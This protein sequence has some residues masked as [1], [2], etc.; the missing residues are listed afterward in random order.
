MFQ[1]P[2]NYIYELNFI[3]IFSPINNNGPISILNAIP[4][5]FKNIVTKFLTSCL[6]PEIIHE[7]FGFKQNSSTELNL[8]TYVDIL[9]DILERGEEVHSIYI[10]P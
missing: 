7:Q 2:Q 1:N 4:K 10:E 8:L 6:G 9:M 3:K 5:I